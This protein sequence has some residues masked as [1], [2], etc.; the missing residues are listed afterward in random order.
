MMWFD[1]AF[2]KCHSFVW[3]HLLVPL[4]CDEERLDQR[5][6]QQ[7]KVTYFMASLELRKAEE[8]RKKHVPPLGIGGIGSQQPLVNGFAFAPPTGPH[9][10]GGRRPTGIFAKLYIGQ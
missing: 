1:F 8:H 3:Q 10:H 4:L 7:F 2:V 6:E 9:Q 5:L